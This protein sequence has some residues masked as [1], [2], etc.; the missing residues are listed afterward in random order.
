MGLAFT[1]FAMVLYPLLGWLAGHG[2]PR[3]PV[4]GVTP[5]PTAIF[6]WGLLLLV[7][8]RT[9]LRLTVI[10]LIWSLIGGSAAWLLKVPEDASLP[11]AALAGF[12]LILWKNWLAARAAKR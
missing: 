3:S 11:V 4:F 7:H 8:G 1:L 2:W 9:P 5:C 12:M 10:P 6:T